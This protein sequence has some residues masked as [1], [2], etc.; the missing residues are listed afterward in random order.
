MKSQQKETLSLQAVNDE[1]NGTVKKP[2][3]S[4]AVFL[5]VQE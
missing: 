4:V 3:L 5:Y 2:Q 1:T